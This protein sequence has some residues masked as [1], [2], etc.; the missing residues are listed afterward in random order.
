MKLLH[1]GDLHLGRS[2]GDFDLLGDQRYIL[3]K[4]VEI[5]EKRQV[6]AV[7][8][9]GDVYDRPVPGEGAVRLLDYFLNRL[10]GLG[11]RVLMI[12]GNHDSDERLNFGSSFFEAR[13]IYIAAKYQGEL[14]H[15]QIDGINFYLLPFV[16]ASQV[17]HFFPEAEI[18]S[19]DQAVKVI[20]Q[21][22]GIDPGACN[23]LVAHQFVA[24][25]GLMPELAGSESAAVQQVGLVE[26][27]GADNFAPFAY[28]ALGHIHRPQQAGRENVRYAGSPLKYSLG[29]CSDAKSVPL[30]A[31][32]ESGRAS[33]ELLPLKPRRDLR[34]L[35]GRLEQLLSRENVQDTDDYIYVTLTDE[36]PLDNAMGIIQGYYPHAVKL[37]YRNSRTLAMEK[38]DV[39]QAAELRSF[40]DLVGD[41]YRLVYGQDISEEEMAVMQEIGVKAGVRDEAR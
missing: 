25:S 33:I 35:T 11:V 5:A 8:I 28:T 37:D 38:E 19:Y 30:I 41:F 20:L 17:R 4:I 15:R 6:D 1:L 9:A 27:I 18:E 24:G 2:L 16:K 26:Q 10:A 14:Y 40:D 29:E 36:E 22:A 7:L 21:Q 32:D 39:F 3:D 31:L 23:V 13:G 12:S 34:H